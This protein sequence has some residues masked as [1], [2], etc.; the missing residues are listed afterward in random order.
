MNNISGKDIA[1]LISWDDM[2]NRHSCIFGN[3]LFENSSEHRYGFLLR[4]INEP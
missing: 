1:A 4:C 2:L 3:N